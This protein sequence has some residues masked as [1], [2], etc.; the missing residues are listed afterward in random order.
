M[1][2]ACLSPTSP[3]VKKGSFSFS[4]VK[5][6]N[7][8]QNALL[9]KYD[10]EKEE[11]QKQMSQLGSKHEVEKCDLDDSHLDQ[12]RKR[13]NPEMEVVF[14]KDSDEDGDL[15]TQIKDKKKELDD[16]IKKWK[17]SKTQ[18]TTIDLT[19]NASDGDNIDDKKELPLDRSE[20]VEVTDTLEIQQKS[21]NIKETQNMQTALVIDDETEGQEKVVDAVCI[22]ESE[23]ESSSGDV[24]AFVEQKDGIVDDRESNVS[25][26]SI[27]KVGTLMTTDA[28]NDVVEDKTNA[29]SSDSLHEVETIPTENAAINVVKDEESSVSPDILGESQRTLSTD[30]IAEADKEDLPHP[31]TQKDAHVHIKAQD[32][33]EIVVV[34][35]Q[36][37][38]GEGRVEMDVDEPVPGPSG[39]PLEWQGATAVG[40]M[41]S[42][43]QSRFN[44]IL[45]DVAF[46]SLSGRVGRH[47]N[48]SGI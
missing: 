4:P 47:S 13:S 40:V 18:K 44:E 14:A 27:Q 48:G 6:K 7:L 2:E 36:D 37:S 33:E 31:G 29:V 16:L 1:A 10:N 42:P 17:T 21:N 3:Q 34:E 8:L 30:V 9:G 20:I 32:N 23:S 11:S 19:A 5:I 46:V 28:I 25:S 22:S 45:S 35:K 38:S 15:L 39:L 26:N 41:Q 43:V 24:T 12:L